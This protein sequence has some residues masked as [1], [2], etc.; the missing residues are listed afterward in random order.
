MR[1][2][3]GPMVWGCPWHSCKLSPW[4]LLRMWNRHLSEAN[5]HTTI[6]PHPVRNA[7]N[8]CEHLTIVYR[9]VCCTSG[10]SGDT[11]CIARWWKVRAGM[12]VGP[13]SLSRG[14]L[15]PHSRQGGPQKAARGD[16]KASPNRARPA[17]P[18]WARRGPP[19]KENYMGHEMRARFGPAMRAHFG[20]VFWPVLLGFSERAWPSLGT[21]RRPCFGQTSS[22][23]FGQPHTQNAQP[24][25]RKWGHGRYIANETARQ[26]PC[27]SDD[28]LL[29]GGE[30]RRDGALPMSRPPRAESYPLP[31]RTISALANK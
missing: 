8:R 14:F 17:S 7:L 31:Q 21:L 1:P 4:P 28:L 9:N 20:P 22:V 13:T 2:R 24:V 16:Q 12:A 30:S 11:K 19:L 10:H 23:F 5:T 6:R 15:P 27:K 18:I 26:Q 29:E 25:P 3:G